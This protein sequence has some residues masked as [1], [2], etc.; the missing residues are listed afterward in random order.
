MLIDVSFNPE[1]FVTVTSVVGS[2]LLSHISVVVDISL[3]LET[4]K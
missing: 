3:K 2:E 1:L 4:S